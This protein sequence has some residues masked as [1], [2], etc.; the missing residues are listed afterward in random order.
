MSALLSRLDTVLSKNNAPRN[1]STCLAIVRP[2]SATQIAMLGDNR[3]LDK[4]ERFFWR[5]DLSHPC[6][7]PCMDLCI[8]P[9]MDACMDPSMDPCMDLSMDPWIHGFRKT[10]ENIFSFQKGSTIPP[11]VITPTRPAPASPDGGFPPI[12]GLAPPDSPLEC[13]HFASF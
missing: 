11:R 5:A 10:S 4:K 1:G 9:C 7:D 6:M 8:D 2:A 12:R 13:V 3:S